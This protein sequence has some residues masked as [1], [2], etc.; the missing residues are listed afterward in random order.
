MRSTTD[1]SFFSVSAATA[2]IEFSG[3]CS[4]TAE[5]GSSF[6][7]PQK[8]ALSVRTGSTCSLRVAFSDL[9]AR[10][11]RKRPCGVRET[12][13]SDLTAGIP[14]SALDSNLGMRSDQ[15]DRF[16]DRIKKFGAES[17]RR[18]LA[19]ETNIG[20]ASD[21]EPRG[22]ARTSCLPSTMMRRSDPGCSHAFERD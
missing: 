2:S 16:S 7:F 12:V 18:S 15:I 8:S 6:G 5:D 20:F 19:T 1:G 17:E 13:D 21:A 4:A 11:R 3:I 14:P 22:L 9:T 10:S